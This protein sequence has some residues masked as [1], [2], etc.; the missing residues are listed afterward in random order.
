MLKIYTPVNIIAPLPLPLKKNVHYTFI[1]KS[2][3][4]LSIQVH[5]KFSQKLDNAGKRIKIVLHD[6][7]MVAMKSG[8]TSICIKIALPTVYIITKKGRHLIIKCS[9]NAENISL[10]EIS[11]WK[12]PYRDCMLCDTI[13]THDMHSKYFCVLGI[14]VCSANQFS[15]GREDKRYQVQH[16]K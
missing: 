8:S 10:F 15:R 5:R 12:T 13:V 3:T 11:Q 4:S 2:G 1:H 16:T 6:T 14:F 9:N 7:G